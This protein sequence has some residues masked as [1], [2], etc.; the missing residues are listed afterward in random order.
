MIKVRLLLPLTTVSLLP[1]HTIFSRDLSQASLEEMV[2]T[3][4]LMLWNFWLL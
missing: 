3:V 4:R 2:R 1:I